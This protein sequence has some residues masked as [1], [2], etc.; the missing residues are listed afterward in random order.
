[1]HTLNTELSRPIGS[2]TEKEEQKAEQ[3]EKQFY[4]KQMELEKL[5]TSNQRKQER[6][7]LLLA[8]N[9]DK[10]KELR[11]IGKKIDQIEY[12]CELEDIEDPEEL[13]KNSEKY[14]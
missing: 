2:K 4:E 8:K 3:A 10:Q 13:K 7:T 1:M 5:Q 14:E 11:H 6:L 12:D 9:A